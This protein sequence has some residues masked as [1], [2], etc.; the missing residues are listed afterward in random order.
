M[1]KKAKALALPLINQVFLPILVLC[2]SLACLWF[3]NRVLKG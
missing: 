3:V 2:F 1:R